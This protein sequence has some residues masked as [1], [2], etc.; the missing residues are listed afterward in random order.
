[1]AAHYGARPSD[2]LRINNQLAALNFDLALYYLARDYEAQ[3]RKRQEKEQ[4]F[5]SKAGNDQT[6][7]RLREYLVKQE[8]ESTAAG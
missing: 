5:V 7:K 2:V 3:E 1:M 4:Q 6:R 8:R